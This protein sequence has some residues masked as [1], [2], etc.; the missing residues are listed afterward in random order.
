MME[1]RGGIRN[2]HGGTR[3]L[4]GQ[5]LPLAAA[6]V[7]QFGTWGSCLPAVREGSSGPS[8]SQLPNS[9]C[10]LLSALVCVCCA[11]LE[12]VKEK[13]GTSI[14][15]TGTSVGILSGSS[16]SL[17]MQGEAAGPVTYPQYE[18]DS[19]STGFFPEYGWLST[20]KCGIRRIED[21]G[22]PSRFPA[23]LYSCFG[24]HCPSP[25]KVSV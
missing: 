18:G 23:K 14:P 16:G 13:H 4:Q 24:T 12:P 5:L 11:C 15:Q 7:P 21:F 9:F 10:L 2:L 17:L 3:E 19:S 22:T 20:W 25:T 8:K 1:L 6:P